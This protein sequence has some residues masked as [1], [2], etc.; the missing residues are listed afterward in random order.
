MIGILAKNTA[1]D[2][3]E[4][5]VRANASWYFQECYFS[6]LD[7]ATVFFSALYYP[8]YLWSFVSEIGNKLVSWRPKHSGHALND[9]ELDFVALSVEQSVSHS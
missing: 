7:E 3:W 8:R 2:D 9:I 1:Q 6:K 5:R 4:D